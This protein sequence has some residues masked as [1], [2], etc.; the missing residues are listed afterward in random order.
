MSEMLSSDSQSIDMSFCEF[1]PFST[2]RVSH[3][4]SPPTSDPLTGYGTYIRQIQFVCIQMLKDFVKQDCIT[5]NKYTSPLECSS[6]QISLPPCI[7]AC[8]LSLYSP[9]CTVFYTAFMV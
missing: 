1:C 7:T 6:L 3:S 4:Y 9:Y 5:G 2:V 8:Y